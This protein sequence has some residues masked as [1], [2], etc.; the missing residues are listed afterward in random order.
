[1]SLHETVECDALAPLIN[2]IASAL[3]NHHG[4]NAKDY[5]ECFTDGIVF[6]DLMQRS[7]ERGGLVTVTEFVVQTVKDLNSG[8][9]SLPSRRP[10]RCN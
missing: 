3:A 6:G 7:Y 8:T 5:W 1:M 10:F 9:S 4:E 2:A